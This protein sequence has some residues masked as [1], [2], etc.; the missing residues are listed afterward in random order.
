MH[1]AGG[2]AGSCASHSMPAG[3]AALVVGYRFERDVPG[4]VGE[5]PA[6]N[7]AG[8]GQEEAVTAALMASTRT[9]GSSTVR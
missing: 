9:R 5:V 6:G 8:R 2:V 7:K 3:E 1:S 4:D